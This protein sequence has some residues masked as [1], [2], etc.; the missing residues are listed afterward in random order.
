M[1][2][3]IFLNLHRRY[4]NVKPSYGGFLGIYQ[5]AAFLRENGYDAQGFSGS[6][7]EGK[8]ILDQICQEEMVSMVGLYCDYANIT[9]NIFLS[10]YIKDTYGLPVIVG[11]PQATSLREDFM[12]KSKCDA[13]VRYEG[14]MTV[15]ELAQYFIDGSGSLDSMLGIMTYEEGVCRIHPERP[16]IENLDAL[17]VVD[18]LCYV[19]PSARVDELNVMTGRGCPFHCAFCHEGHHS[20]KV[21][22]RSVE[23]VLQEIRDFLERKAKHRHVY[24]LFTDDTFTLIPKRVKAI[25]A[26]LKELKKTYN[27]TWYCEGHVHMLYKNPQ[28]IDDMAEAGCLRIQLGIESGNQ[29]VLDAYDKGCT[30]EEIEAVVQHALDSGIEQIFGNIILGSA[31]ASKETYE[32]DKVFAQKLLRLGAGRMEFGVVSYWP[33][34]ETPMTTHPDDFGIQ[35]EDARFEQAADDFPQVRTEAF[36]R[37]QISQLVQQLRFELNDYMKGMIRRGEIA[38]SRILSWF[39]LSSHYKVSGSWYSL[40]EAMPAEYG[41]YEM[42]HTKEV[43]ESKDLSVEAFYTSH[44]M[45]VL[46]LNYYITYPD[47]NHFDLMDLHLSELEQQVLLYSVGKLSVRE[48]TQRIIKNPEEMDAGIEQVVQALKRLEKKHLVLFSLY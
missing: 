42:L 38:T 41:Y 11:G 34:A 1:D 28:M 2:D 16:V 7:M 35:I 12:A 37:I 36:T 19:Y 17:P 4:T 20:R 23:N 18:D 3:V 13:V 33:L 22:F 32:R 40:L 10:R 29:F 31:F 43:C 47:D 48:I 44:P 46:S 6:L 45:R 27:F 25:C 9:E 30:L 21:R 24:V 14:E 39:D 15:L 26:G 8:R 5:L